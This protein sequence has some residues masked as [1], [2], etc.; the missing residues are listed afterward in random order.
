VRRW[1]NNIKKGLKQTGYED[2]ME[3]IWLRTGTSGGLVP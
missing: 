1:E 2:V 3:F